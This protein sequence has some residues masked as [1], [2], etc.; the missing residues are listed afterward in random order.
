MLE[1]APQLGDLRV[2]ARP[3]GDWARADRL[4][5]G[6]GQRPGLQWARHH[7]RLPHLRAELVALA[8]NSGVRNVAE[9]ARVTDVSRDTIYADLRKH[10]IDYA[11]QIARRTA[12][13]YEPLTPAAVTGLGDLVSARVAPA[14]LADRPQPAAL[15]AWLAGIIL[16]RVESCSAPQPAS[17]PTCTA[18]LRSTP[19][20]ISCSA[21]TS[22]SSP[23]S[24]V[25]VVPWKYSSIDVPAADRPAG[26]ALVTAGRS[27]RAIEVP[28]TRIRVP[29]GP[30]RDDRQR[31]SSAR[32][33]RGDSARKISRRSSPGTS[34]SI[35]TQRHD[36]W[37]TA[38]K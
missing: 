34:Y 3:A 6:G 8:W 22:P 10:G 24:A 11:D 19:G 26:T 38:H 17:R 23:T 32:P 28:P 37:I 14:M 21:T 20:R 15:I 27:P 18:S 29:H 16:D 36:Q 1:V 9:L 33:P 35:R 4:G 7:D 13:R 31:S 30:P 5:E 2:D 25:C 12:P